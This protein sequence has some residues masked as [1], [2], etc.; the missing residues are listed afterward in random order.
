MEPLETLLELEALKRLKA[1]YFFF[2]DTKAWPE[3]L[4]LFTPDVT[5]KWDL[6]VAAPGQDGQTT[7]PLVG[8]EAIAAVMPPAMAR[9]QSIH[10]GHTPILDLISP[11]TATGIWA[12]EE[13]VGAPDRDWITYGYGHYHE[14][15]RKD[16]GRWRIASLH[17]TRLRVGRISL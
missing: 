6:A 14:T 4:A 15:Y 2:L 9:L 7:D 8:V 16:D 3:W 1:E 13:R 17:L 5:L 10:H 12:M 11:T